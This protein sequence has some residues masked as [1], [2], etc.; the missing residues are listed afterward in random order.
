MKLSQSYLF[1]YI[2]T[3]FVAGIHYVKVFWSEMVISHHSHVA[4]ATKTVH[5]LTKI[6]LTGSGLKE[7]IIRKNAEFVIEAPSAG[8]SN[9]ILS[10]FFL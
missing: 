6:I 4:Y 7:A 10:L 8:S 2:F 9:P 5:D 1:S 3:L